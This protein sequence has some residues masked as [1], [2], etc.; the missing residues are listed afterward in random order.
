MDRNAKLRTTSE[1]TDI[2]QQSNPLSCHKY[3]EIHYNIEQHK[4]QGYQIE[5]GAE[6]NI[7][8]KKSKVGKMK[9]VQ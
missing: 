3:R 7:F 1:T 8:S 6:S 4:N 9:N 2:H 5:S